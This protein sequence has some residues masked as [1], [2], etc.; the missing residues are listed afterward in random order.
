MEL[1]EKDIYVPQIRKLGVPIYSFADRFS[2]AAKLIFLRGLVRQLKPE[3]LHS[4]SAYL[5]FAVYWSTRYTHTIGI[6]CTRSNFVFDWEGS[7]QWLT[8]LNTRWPR[9]QIFNSFEAARAA[10]GAKRLFMPR[11]VY[12]VRNGV[13]L[14]SFRTSPIL[15]TGRTNIVGIGSLVPIKRWDKLLTAAYELKRRNSKFSLQ[16]AGDGPLRE[17]LEEQVVNRVLENQIRFLGHVNDVARFLSDASFLVHASDAEGCPNAVMEAMACGRAVVATDVGDVP[18]LVDDGKTG[19]VV[20]RGDDAMLVERM[21]IL[22]NDPNLCNSM[23][24]A[25]RIKAERDFGLDQLVRGTLEAYR[26]AGWTDTS[27]NRNDVSYIVERTA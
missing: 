17:S 16:I 10:A 12:V 2:S 13:D 15:N 18:F 8:R 22:I 26:A 4:Y 20:R 5:N 6:G 19:F 21:A 23:G 9:K 3:V 1:S 27:V 14:E 7:S 11:H 24:L 25:G